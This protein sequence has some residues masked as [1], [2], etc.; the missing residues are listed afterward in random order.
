MIFVVVLQ[1]KLLATKTISKMIK[2]KILML[3]LLMGFAFTSCFEGDNF[4]RYTDY[5]TMEAGLLPDSMVVNTSFNLPIRATA[6]NGCWSGIRVYVN[7]K[8][9]SA[10]YISAAGTF[11]NHGEPCSQQLV[12][13]DTVY[14]FTPKVNKTHLFYFYNPTGNPQIRIDTVYIKVQ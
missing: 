11:E 1:S 2:P 8:A 9:D 7:V 4:I 3:P 10:Y 14:V 13:H 12:V 5:V 6:P